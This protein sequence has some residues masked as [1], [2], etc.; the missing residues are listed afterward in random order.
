MYKRSTTQYL[1]TKETFCIQYVEN[2]HASG[3]EA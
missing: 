3:E 2:I 1:Y